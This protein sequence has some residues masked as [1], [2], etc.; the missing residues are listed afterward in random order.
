MSKTLLK[1]S[2]SF[3]PAFLLLLSGCTNEAS[4]PEPVGD[5][6]QHYDW[7]MKE[8]E[9]NEKLIAESN[10]TKNATQL[11]RRSFSTPAEE[12]RERVTGIEDSTAPGAKDF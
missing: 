7:L 11:G 1:A 8:C 10:Y 6:K 3:V 9:V 12:L 5:T 4:P 2:V